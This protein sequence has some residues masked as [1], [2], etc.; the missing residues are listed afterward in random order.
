MTTEAFIEKLREA[1]PE[2]T[3]AEAVRLWNERK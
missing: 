2:G 1:D 3:K